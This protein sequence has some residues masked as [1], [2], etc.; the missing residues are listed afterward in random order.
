MQTETINVT[1]NPNFDEKDEAALRIVSKIL[2]M[3]FLK[4]QKSS[5]SQALGTPCYLMR[6]VAKN[7]KTH[8]E[9]VISVEETTKEEI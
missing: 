8:K 7:P 1:A 2:I 9:Y 4:S 3:L 5:V 6:V